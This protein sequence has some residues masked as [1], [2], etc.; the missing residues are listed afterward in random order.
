MSHFNK[1]KTPYLKVPNFN[2]IDLDKVNTISE[3]YFRAKMFSLKHIIKHIITIKI[4][5]SH[6]VK[7]KVILKTKVIMKKIFHMHYH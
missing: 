1:K 2:L 7:T 4:K 3:Y 5:N 6:S